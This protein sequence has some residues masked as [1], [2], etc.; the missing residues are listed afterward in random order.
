MSRTERET[1]SGRV[2]GKV[3]SKAEAAFDSELEGR[4]HY[5]MRKAGAFPFLDEALDLRLLELGV[6]PSDVEE[7]FIRGSGP[8]GQKVNKT[9][10]TV[11]LIH[12][13]SGLQV[14]CQGGR[15]QSQNR[16]NAWRGL[17]EK[18][19]ESRNK[20]LKIFQNQLEAERRRNRPKSASQKRRM[21][22]T[23]RVRARKKSNRG[24]FSWD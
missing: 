22:E 12:R 21:V 11:W 23:K 3:W 9:S 10:S 14:K 15:S 4:F 6:S 8:G 19:E 2:R 24:S 5:R 17:A 16:L 7:R 1:C 20:S 13:P 18:L